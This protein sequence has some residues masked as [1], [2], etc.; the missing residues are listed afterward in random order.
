MLHTSGV[1]AGLVAAFVFSITIAKVLRLI[2]S[3]AYD[4]T[5]RAARE[6]HEL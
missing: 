4:A 2:R 6:A 5:L 3:L 1:A